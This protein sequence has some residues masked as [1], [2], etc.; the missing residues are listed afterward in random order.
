MAHSQKRQKLLDHFLL[1]LLGRIAGHRTRI[2][3]GIR[4]FVQHRAHLSKSPPAILLPVLAF[5]ALVLVHDVGVSDSSDAAVAE[6]HLVT[7]EGAGFVAENVFNL[8]ELF[9]EGGRAAEGGCV[10]A[11]VVHV[12][13]GVDQLG[14]LEFDDF[15]RDDEGNGDEI[16]VENDECEDVYRA[17]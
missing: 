2:N 8:A 5:P 16:V 6:F 1:S 3:E 13:V 14:L 17:V 10:G 11:G 15:H 12:Q 4:S 7:G 9:D